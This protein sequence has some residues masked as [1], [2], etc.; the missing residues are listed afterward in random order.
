[1]VEP[2]SKREEDQR[3]REDNE[4]GGGGGKYDNSS[5]TT[6]RTWT[7][8]KDEEDE[9]W[10]A[11]HYIATHSHSKYWFLFILSYFLIVLTT[12]VIPVQGSEELPNTQSASIPATIFISDT[13]FYSVHITSSLYWLLLLYQSKDPKNIS[14]PKPHRYQLL[15]PQTSPMQ[16]QVKFLLYSYHAHLSSNL[17]TDTRTDTNPISPKLD[18][19][20]FPNAEMCNSPT[21]DIDGPLE[22]IDVAPKAPVIDPQFADSGSYSSSSMVSALAVNTS[23]SRLN[24]SGS[25][26]ALVRLSA[27]LIF[28]VTL[29]ADMDDRPRRLIS[30]IPC[31]CRFF[32]RYMYWSCLSFSSEIFGE[33]STATSSRL[34]TVQENIE[35]KSASK[36][37]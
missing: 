34:K 4:D 13:G 5:Q 2:T 36:P 14:I 37:R 16:N 31:T 20:L 24:S 23:S 17:A 21:P 12:S 33:P 15:L 1:M 18:L 11:P 7:K 8:E 28:I 6:F 32:L 9:S 29:V 27:V 19:P 25:D 10:Q 3:R 26:G 30:L 35:A 22:Y